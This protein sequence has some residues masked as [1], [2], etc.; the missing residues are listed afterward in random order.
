[1]K[2]IMKFPQNFLDLKIRSIAGELKKCLEKDQCNPLYNAIFVI[3]G[4]KRFQ[5]FL[6]ELCKPVFFHKRKS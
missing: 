5:V 3:D 6:N 4:Q 2:M 1:M